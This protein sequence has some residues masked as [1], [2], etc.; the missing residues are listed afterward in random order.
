VLSRHFRR[1]GFRH[2]VDEHIDTFARIKEVVMKHRFSR[3]SLL[4]GSVLLIGAL[5]LWSETVAAR[6]NVAAGA[7]SAMY[8]A[9]CHGPDGNSTYTGTPRLA[10]QSAESIAAKIKLYK[11]NKKV[12]HPM[13][14]FLAGGLTDQDIDDLAA[15][16][17][18]QPVKQGEMPYSGPPPLK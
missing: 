16:Y 17:S 11:S 13:M 9:Y 14:A 12:F 4:L 8:C 6:G 7:K 2:R 1:V 3:K 5:G 15:F 10:G 18:S